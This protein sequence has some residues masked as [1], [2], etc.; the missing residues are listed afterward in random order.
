MLNP[1]SAHAHSCCRL[2]FPASLIG[3]SVRRNHDGSWQS[4]KTAA[5]FNQLSLLSSSCEHKRKK[6]HFSHERVRGRISFM[7]RL[8][9]RLRGGA[10]RMFGHDH[11]KTDD[12]ELDA[13]LLDI[14]QALA[15]VAD[16]TLAE[17]QSK[18]TL[19]CCRLST[20]N[21]PEKRADRFAL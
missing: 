21:H 20:T 3:T 16:S 2:N 15:Q 12:S 4:M 9:H 5:G 8:T 11:T 1:L 13:D 19:I 10:V 6:N 14:D 18:A 17:S 7:D